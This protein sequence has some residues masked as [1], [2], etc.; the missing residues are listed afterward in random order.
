ME[1]D[2]ESEEQSE[3][4]RIVF[5]YDQQDRLETLGFVEPSGAVMIVHTDGS[6]SSGVLG[7]EIDEVAPATQKALNCNKL[8]RE[9]KTT[10]SHMKACAVAQCRWANCAI[11]GSCAGGQSAKWLR[12]YASYQCFGVA[13]KGSGIN[14][15]V[16]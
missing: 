7:G 8:A 6:V 1:S 13:P 4:S 15:I 9:L 10:N 3:F 16:P 11:Y 14:I 12:L 5:T 2:G